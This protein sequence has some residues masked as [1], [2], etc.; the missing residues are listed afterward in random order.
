[1]TPLS[2]T[3]AL[4]VLLGWIA[5]LEGVGQGLSYEQSCL[6]GI[7][8][9]WGFLFLG[10]SAFPP[11]YFPVALAVTAAVLFG[12]FWVVRS[13]IQE[14]VLPPSPF[15]GEGQV[16]F[17][18][19]WGGKRA[20]LIKE[21]SMG[22]LVKIPSSKAIKEGDRIA[23][24]GFPVQLPKSSRPGN[25]DE[26]L[27]WKAHGAFFQLLPLEI[28]EAGKTTNLLLRWRRILRERVLLTLPPL[29][30]GHILSA[31][32]GIT[33]PDLAKDHR[34]W[35]TSHLLAVS[36]FNVA[37]VEGWVWFVL[38]RSRFRFLGMSIA[39]WV[40]M[41]L[42][43]SQPSA[44]RAAWMVQIILLGKQIGRPSETLNSISV[45]ALCLLLWRPWWYWDVGWRLSVL[46]ALVLAALAKAG[47]ASKWFFWVSSPAVWIVTAAQCTWTFG[48]VPLVGLLTNFVAIPLYSFLFPVGSLL[49]LPSLL[50]LP[51]G[52]QLALVGEGLFHFWEIIANGMASFIPWNLSWSPVL[53]GLATALFSGLLALGMG[54]TRFRT[55]LAALFTLLGTALFLR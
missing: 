7:L 45:A 4:L 41:V 15:Q 20:L 24:R 36:G 46:A 21:G 13:A 12:G 39:L 50:G 52:F 43:G 18:R 5:A 25:F 53:M 37:I 3:P 49:A 9:A 30:R 44:L 47:C 51:G 48:V 40:Y 11:G 6:L 38:K 2:K 32:L 10:T 22:F 31:W 17:E 1:M 16:V 26:S 35:G 29:V 55:L 23:Y 8:V 54:F 42:S 28:T 33:D 14:P 19:P 27:Y 34:R